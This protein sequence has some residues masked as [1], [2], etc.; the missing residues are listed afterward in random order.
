MRGIE[1]RQVEIEQSRSMIQDQ[2]RQMPDFVISLTGKGLS[3]QEA[4]NYAQRERDALLAMD[5]AHQVELQSLNDRRREVEIENA[6]GYYS[7]ELEQGDMSK[8]A[9]AKPMTDYER[10]SY[11]TNRQDVKGTELSFPRN[12]S[13]EQL[14]Q[15]GYDKSVL[16]AVESVQ[17]AVMSGKSDIDARER[18]TSQ[19]RY[20]YNPKGRTNLDNALRQIHQELGHEGQGMPPPSIQMA[21]ARRMAGIIRDGAIATKSEKAAK[22]RRAEPKI[23]HG[24]RPF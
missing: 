17:N 11:N 8:A 13:R 9:Q 22:A 20:A 4:Q 15:Y 19:L 24:A 18:L 3:L 2:I 1:D 16:D 7:P 6:T 14:E 23:T 10:Q 21:A 12:A 5:S